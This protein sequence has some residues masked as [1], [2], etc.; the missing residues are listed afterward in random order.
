MHQKTI[1][2][3]FPNFYLSLILDKQINY[4]REMQ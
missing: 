2:F 1:K 4:K 3:K